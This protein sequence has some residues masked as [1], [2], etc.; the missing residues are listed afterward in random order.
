MHTVDRF[1][2][3]ACFSCD[4]V[5]NQMCFMCLLEKS[6]VQHLNKKMFAVLQGS[7]EALVQ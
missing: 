4:E 7:A 1:V 3:E 6:G 2:N 5:I